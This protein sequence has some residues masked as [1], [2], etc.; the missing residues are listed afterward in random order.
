MLNILSHLSQ[1]GIIPPDTITLTVSMTPSRVDLTCETLGGPVTR[2][3]R[4]NPESYRCLSDLIC[5]AY[6]GLISPSAD[7][8]EVTMRVDEMVKITEERYVENCDG[9]SFIIAAMA[10]AGPKVTWESLPA[11]LPADNPC[12]G[13][14]TKSP[15]AR[16][17]FLP[18]YCSTTCYAKASQAGPREG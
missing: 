4:Y 18:Y 1:A 16:V 12:A 14:G 6:P 15:T 9:L 5:R 2:A 11:P 13:C 10:P 7:Y 17:G 8:W 3:I